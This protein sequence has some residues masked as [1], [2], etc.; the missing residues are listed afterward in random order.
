M[1]GPADRVPHNTAPEVNRAI[2]HEIAKDILHLREHPNEI[3]PRLRE[4]DREWDIERA[5]ATM[6]STLSLLGL[7]LGFSG[8]RRWF[9]LP[10]L[11]QGFYLQHA[12][13]GWCPPLPLLRRLGFRTPTEIERERCALKALVSDRMKGERGE[14]WTQEEHAVRD[15]RPDDASMRH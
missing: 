14:G 15:Y 3:P 7:A 5:L 13:Q 12:V 9:G 8:R 1:P 10:V 6:S 2:R 4:L 11:I